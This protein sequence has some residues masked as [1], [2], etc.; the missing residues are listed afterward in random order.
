MSIRSKTDQKSKELKSA[1]D[2]SG[3]YPGCLSDH[4]RARA[5]QLFENHGRPP[6]RELDDWFQ[7][8]RET[9]QHWGIQ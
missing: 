7:A 5:Y 4:I 1:A 3:F 9:K 2:P 6:G 8:E